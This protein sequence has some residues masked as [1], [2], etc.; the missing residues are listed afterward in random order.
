MTTQTGNKIIE[1]IKAHQQARVVELV[2][3]LG[4]TPS[5][6]HRQLNKLQRKGLIEKIGVFPKVY[7]HL[8]TAKKETVPVLEPGL[9]KFLEKNYLYISPSGE[10]LPGVTGFWE[11]AVKT[12]QDKNFQALA[13]EYLRTRQAADKFYG[14]DGLIDDAVGSGATFNEAAKKLRKTD[15]VTNKIICFAV[16]GSYK[17]F[18]VIREV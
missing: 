15:V 14:R 4:F 5:A 6:I 7:Y 9:T 18:D 8:K 17:G 2:Q 1:F 13:N 3:I 12:K 11:W 10:I 16:V